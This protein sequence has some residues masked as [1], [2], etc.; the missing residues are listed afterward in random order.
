[1]AAFPTIGIAA[2]AYQTKRQVSE[3]A[4]LPSVLQM[5]VNSFSPRNLLYN[6]IG[7]FST[8]RFPRKSLIDFDVSSP[9]ALSSRIIYR[10]GRSRFLIA[11]KFVTRLSSHG[12]KRRTGEGNMPLRRHPNIVGLPDRGYTAGLSEWGSFDNSLKK[13]LRRRPGEETEVRAPRSKNSEGG[14]TMH[15]MWHPPRANDALNSSRGE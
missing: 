3:H 12:K 2:Y 13:S 6:N 5:A 15:D 4:R 9:S 8:S 1:M 7:L 14:S 10:R 11:T